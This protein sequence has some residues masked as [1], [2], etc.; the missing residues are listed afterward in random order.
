MRAIVINSYGSP[1]VLQLSSVADPEPGP[2]KLLIEVRAAGVNPIDWKIRKGNFRFITGR[3]FPRILGADIAGVVKKTGNKVAGFKPGDEVMAMV[4]IFAGNGGYAELA[5][6]DV[7]YTCSKPANLTFI[8]AAAVPGS[9]VTALQVLQNKAHLEEGTRL[10]INGASGGVGTYAVQIAKNLGARITAVCSGRNKDLVASLGADRVIDYTNA[11]F[12][13]QD[14]IYDVIFD[15]VGNLH[16]TACRRVL[17]AG[18]AFITIVP[19]AAK[20]LFSL[21]TAFLPGKRCRFVSVMPKKHD[22]LWLKQKIEEQR[23]RVVLDRTYPL[24]KAGEAHAYME[25]GHA[26]GKVVLTL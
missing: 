21:L 16:F 3:R 9:G 18:G 17:S 26:R 10:L 4:N 23:L 1:E 13:R 25:K 6:A 19:D 20:I 2:Q 15:A 8:E 14:H 22:L 24:E 5:L 11:D 12:T 7:K